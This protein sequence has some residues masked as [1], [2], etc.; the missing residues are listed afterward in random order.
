MGSWRQRRSTLLPQAKLSSGFLQRI[1]NRFEQNSHG[2]KI[3]VSHHRECG[4][5]ACATLLPLAK[6]GSVLVIRNIDVKKIL[7]SPTVVVKLVSVF[8]LSGGLF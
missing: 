2:I 8:L 6:L 1:R 4:Q 5:L 7:F 3:P